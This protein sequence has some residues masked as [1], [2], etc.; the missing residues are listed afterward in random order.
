MIAKF[1]FVT[2]FRGKLRRFSCCNVFG[3]PRSSGQVSNATHGVMAMRAPSGHLIGFR[4]GLT[5]ILPPDNGKFFYSCHS[6]AILPNDMTALAECV[7]RLPI[8]AAPEN[9][10][11][12]ATAKFAWFFAGFPSV[13]ASIGL[14]LGWDA[15]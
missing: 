6:S 10:P 4:F 8:K 12:A 7:R 13:I 2:A 9:S 15:S 11:R 5:F 1:L 14:D 3:P